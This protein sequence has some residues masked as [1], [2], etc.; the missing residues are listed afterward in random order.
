MEEL[1]RILPESFK[2]E[3]E[4][5]E[6][7]SDSVD[8]FKA[9]V[10]LECKSEQEILVW[11]KEMES[12]VAYQTGFNLVKELLSDA[13]VGFGGN[14]SPRIFM[15][16]DSAAEKLG[17]RNVFPNSRQYLCQ[18]HVAQAMWRWLWN[19]ANG[20]QLDDRRPLMLAFRKIMYSSTVAEAMNLFEDTMGQVEIKHPKFARAKERKKVLSE[21]SS[22]SNQF[23]NDPGVLKGLETFLNRITKVSNASSYAS[24]LCSAGNAVSLRAHSRARI[25]TQ[26]T[27]RNRRTTTANRGAKRIPAGR[28]SLSQ[29][30]KATKRRRSLYKN[31]MQNM[32]NA[33]SHGT[34]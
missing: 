26:P 19:S 4:S 5:L 21:I 12:A 32:P 17:L 28:P 14:G 34:S 3:I 6:D 24:L 29:Q 20:I 8:K 9:V 10:R 13:G 15:T 11:K 22:K 1:K 7:V 23:G 31:V 27:S 25:L 30:L 33:K 16:D 18:F 2:Y